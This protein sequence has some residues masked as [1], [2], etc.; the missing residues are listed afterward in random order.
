MRADNIVKYDFQGPWFCQARRRFEQHRQKYDEKKDPV[1]P[2]EMTKPET[3]K[4]TSYR[5]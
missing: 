3:H 5:S 2:N 1:G 4:R